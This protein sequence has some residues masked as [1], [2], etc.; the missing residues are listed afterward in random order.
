MPP[1]GKILQFT[2]IDEIRRTQSDAPNKMICLELIRFDEDGR[3][4]LRLGYYILGKLP[5]MRDRW[6]W[7]QYATFLPLK[8]F[9]AVVRQARRRGWIS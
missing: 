8:D 7:G 2:V 6:V 3:K 5:T 9:S 4:E 1:H